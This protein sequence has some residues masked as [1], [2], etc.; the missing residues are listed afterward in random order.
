ML[1]RLFLL[2]V[3][4]FSLTLTA[5]A[6]KPSARA[7]EEICL[8]E[9][10]RTLWT[11]DGERLLVG[12]ETGFA[13]YHVDD[14]SHP[15]HTF[16]D[17][18]LTAS[19]YQRMDT[20]NRL[21]LTDNRLIDLDAG[22][23]ITT[24][25]GTETVSLSATGQYVFADDG[26]YDAETGTRIL[27]TPFLARQNTDIPDLVYSGGLVEGSFAIYV[28]DLREPDAPPIIIDTGIDR[29]AWN[30]AFSPDGT[31]MTQTSSDGIKLIDLQRGVTIAILEQDYPESVFAR[32]SPEGRYL[33]TNSASPSGTSR[34]DYGYGFRIWDSATGEL[35]FSATM[36]R[37][38]TILDDN[39]VLYQE[40]NQPGSV[41]GIYLWRQGEEPQLLGEIQPLLENS[42][43]GRIYD[44]YFLARTTTGYGLWAFDALVNGD[45]PFIQ[46]DLPAAS[47]ESLQ[48][49]N[50]FTRVLVFT[51]E[52][53]FVT[54]LPPAVSAILY[55]TSTAMPL[56]TLSV[57][58]PL[59]EQGEP[60]ESQL[61]PDILTQ[62]RAVRFAGNYVYYALNGN[63]F[64]HL[65]QTGELLHSLTNASRVS[66]NA[67]YSYVAYI[68]N[69]AVHWL[70]LSDGTGGTICHIFGE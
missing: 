49:S 22:T 25:A 36:S 14:L 7:Q 63:V 8:G 6:L 17:V 12:A 10:A 4:I 1:K 21:F 26:V 28:Y 58:I 62:Y 64:I 54:P 55:D 65:A 32:F 30:V 48:F 34:W 19:T 44:G 59:N 53:V 27:S 2:I 3:L 29:L 46:T 70:R 45:A 13:V 9:N 47:V 5:L 57:D 42:R 33:L 18:Q 24:F 38:I 23:I 56:L 68:D 16:P 69:G 50:D 11:P 39:S 51:A 31:R 61:D 41:S 20:E 43:S 66:F 60:D 52:Q 67:D 15:F 35:L 40:E 37:D